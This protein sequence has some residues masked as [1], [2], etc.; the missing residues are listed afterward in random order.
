[1]LSFTWVC[2]HQLIFK[3][4]LYTYF[5]ASSFIFYFETISNLREN[6]KCIIRK[7]FSLAMSSGL[8]KVF[9]TSCYQASP[10]MTLQYHHVSNHS[11]KTWTPF[12]SFLCM[13]PLQT[14]Q[15]VIFASYLESV[16]YERAIPVK[17]TVFLL[18]PAKFHFKTNNLK[19]KK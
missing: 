17:T 14:L 11:S 8:N 10:A 19:S 15:T 13:V 18:E 5:T 1:M 9:R 3:P 2:F 6:C 7:L 16:N 12:S 4:C